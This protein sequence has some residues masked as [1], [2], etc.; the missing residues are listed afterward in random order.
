LLA[1]YD[2]LQAAI[3]ATEVRA[4]REVWLQRAVAPWWAHHYAEADAAL[5]QVTSSDP[6]EE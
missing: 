4:Q 6:G 5:A 2:A 3:P 1:T